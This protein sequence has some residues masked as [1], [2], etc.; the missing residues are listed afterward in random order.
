MNS[1]LTWPRERPSFGRVC[2]RPFTTADVHL[3]A[4]LATDPYVPAIG[5]VPTE[6]SHA[7][8]LAWIER[9][10]CRAHDGSGYSFAIADSS[11][12]LAVGAAGLWLRA[13]TE[14]RATAGYS[15]SPLHR[16]RGYAADALAALTS[17]AWTLDDLHRVELYIEPWNAG[18]IR[19]AERAGY[20]REGLLRSHQEIGGMRRDMLLYA[21]LRRSPHASG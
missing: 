13:L 7:E 3:V 21:R 20:V 18:S 12:D 5:S 8:G 2:L 1:E 4:E 6:Y 11:T 14:G 9:Q 15:V 10:H 16:G 17:F 19:T